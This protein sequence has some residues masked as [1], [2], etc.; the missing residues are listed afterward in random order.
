MARQNLLLVDGDARSRRVLEVSLRKAGFSVT[1][2]EGTEQALQFLEHAEPDLIISDTRL[3]GSDG[4]EFCRLVKSNTRWV[5]IPFVFLTSAKGIEDKVKGLELGVEDYLVKP[6]YIKEVTTR[7]RML[8][9]RKQRE[10]LERKDTARTKFTGQLADMAVVDLMQ[11]IEISRKSGTIAFETELGDATV[12]FREGTVIDA[13]MGRLQ[14]ENAIYRLLTLS[15]GAF[16]VEFKPVSRK[17]IISESTQSLLM[18]GMRRVDEW[19]RLLEQLPPIDSVLAV[20]KSALE[21][22]ELN[23]RQ[24]TVLRRFDGKRTILEVVDDSGHDD[25]EALEVISSFY[26]EGVLT[27]SLEGLEDSEDSESGA[28]AL[29]AWGPAPATQFEAPDLTDD[30][31]DTPVEEEEESSSVLPPLPSYPDADPSE[32]EVLG[33]IPEDSGPHPAAISRAAITALQQAEETRDPDEEDP[34]IAALSDKLDAIARGESID[35]ATEPLSDPIPEPVTAQR[36]D[37]FKAELQAIGAPA[38]THEPR[39]LLDQSRRKTQPL[40]RFEPPRPAPVVSE[41]GPVRSVPPEAPIEPGTPA[42]T[43]RDDHTPLFEP[44]DGPPMAWST[45]T[46]EIQTVEGSVNPPMGTPRAAAS[47]SFAA[48]APEEFPPPPTVVAA[49]LE[50]YR[51]ELEDPQA[52]GPSGNVA[53]VLEQPEPAQAPTGETEAVPEDGEPSSGVPEVIHDGP[54]GNLLGSGDEDLA[55][56]ENIVAQHQSTLEGVEV[57]VPTPPPEGEAGPT[58]EEAAD[59]VQADHVED[60]GTVAEGDTVDEFEPIKVRVAAATESMQGRRV[61]PDE[62]EDEDDDDSEDS[63]EGFAA[64]A[65]SNRGWLLV[66]GAVGAVA[67]GGIVWMSATGNKK[68]RKP[69]PV[70]ANASGETGSTGQADGEETDAETGDAAAQTESG[71]AVGET[72]ETGEAGET[73]ET[74]ETGAGETGPDPASETGGPEAETGEPPAETGEPAAETGEPAETGE[75]PPVELDEEAELAK[76]KKLVKRRKYDDAD[77]IVDTL[78]A[79]DPDNAQALLVRS[80]IKLEQEEIHTALSLARQAAGKDPD[81]ADA[82]LYI[83]TI[84]ESLGKESDALQAYRRYLELEPEGRYASGIRASVKKLE[85][86]AG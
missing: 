83:G 33:G 86:A 80:N 53:A 74:G 55:R 69:D 54:S 81:F 61:D 46:A 35:S 44:G 3:P 84:Q 47:G 1:T 24:T 6:I 30:D 28:L 13:Q 2:A 75:E 67:L 60:D 38:P 73:G 56:L 9:Q 19:T 34:V 64:P 62:D 12:W 16:E 45:Q 41:E 29:E 20:E 37:Q 51:Q 4:F 11:T 77:A 15:D 21:G 25:V 58:E 85:K 26:F 23:D 65:A 82:Y 70:G 22:R 59:T 71:E 52:T 48:R 39:P 43:I 5:A 36:S 57:H 63:L 79:A 42:P 76:A 8:L 72:A 18:E 14:G 31:D 32:Q 27:P 66:V 10:R 50:R 17:P 49:E 40:L 7:L 68:K 78:L